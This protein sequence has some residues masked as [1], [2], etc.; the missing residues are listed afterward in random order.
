M[1]SDNRICSFC[2][3]HKPN[4]FSIFRRNLKYLRRGKSNLRNILN[5][6]CCGFILLTLLINFIFVA[7]QILNP[8]SQKCNAKDPPAPDKF[9]EV[10]L[11]AFGPCSPRNDFG[12]QKYSVCIFLKF[13]H[14]PESKLE[15]YNN[16]R[17]LPKS[18]SDDLRNHIQDIS[19]EPKESMV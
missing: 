12:M 9:C 15:Y 14:I 10:D 5:V 4:I 18:M 16:T 1:M 6:S 17:D 7:Y 8:N 19:T 11:D 3:N 2:L 13:R